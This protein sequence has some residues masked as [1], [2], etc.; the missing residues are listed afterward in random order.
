MFSREHL[1]L[2]LCSKLVSKL[3][4]DWA[5]FVNSHRLTV[6]ELL[7]LLNNLNENDLKVLNKEIEKK[8]SSKRELVTQEEFTFI[9]DMFRTKI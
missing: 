7:S 1:T 9:S 6:K 3:I 8:I 2:R 4:C 5:F